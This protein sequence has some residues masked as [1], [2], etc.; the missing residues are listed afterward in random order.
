MILHYDSSGSNA[1]IPVLFV[2]AYPMNGRMWSAQLDALGDAAWCIA[3]DLPG[4]GR[5]PLERG[6]PSMN[7]YA[8]ALD[9]LVS[10]LALPPFVLCGLSMGG[11]IAFAYHRKHGAKLRG[12]VL[13]DTRAEA[14]TPEGRAGRNAQISTIAA[15]NLR[16][17]T[18]A[19]LPKLLGPTTL[20]RKPDVVAAVQSMLEETNADGTS[21][22]LAALAGRAD[23]VE[24]LG[25]IRLPTLIL[26]GD[27]DGLTPPPLAE[28]MRDGIRGSELVRLEGAGH[29]SNLEAPD[30]FNA[31]I[32]QF[33]QRLS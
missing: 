31:A 15:G 18:D 25:K 22:A 4:F 17:V 30:A 2:H 28:R 33:I 21:A 7:A 1:G 3:P 23:S 29:L 12:L 20:S 5:S 16:D 26:V 14:D 6:E 8:D 10:A 9:R 11:Y 32:R 13:S 27:E 19:L 24:T